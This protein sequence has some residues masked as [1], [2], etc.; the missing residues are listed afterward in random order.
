MILLTATATNNGGFRFRVEAPGRDAMETDDPATA[1]AV[2]DNLGVDNPHRYVA[3]AQDW[4]V[5][6]IAPS[7]GGE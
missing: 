3:H 6:E 4:G 7:A 1:A 2:L 5:V